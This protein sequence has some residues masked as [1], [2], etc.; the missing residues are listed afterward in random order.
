MAAR[1]VRLC[2]VECASGW[3]TDVI[4]VFD[5]RHGDTYPGTPWEPKAA[6]TTLAQHYRS[7]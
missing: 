7:Q 5:D 4:K 3:L 6:F 2:R 1:L